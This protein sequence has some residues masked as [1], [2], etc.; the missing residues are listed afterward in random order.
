MVRRHGLTKTALRLSEK[1]ENH[2][3]SDR[4]EVSENFGSCSFPHVSGTT[5]YLSALVVCGNICAHHMQTAPLMA[6]ILTELNFPL[7]SYL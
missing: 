2:S 5:T 1:S 4:E 6:S 3:P 7:A